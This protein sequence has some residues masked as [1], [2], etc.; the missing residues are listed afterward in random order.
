MEI[1][2]FLTVLLCLCLPTLATAQD[3]AEPLKVGVKIAPPFVIKGDDGQFTGISIDLWQLAAEKMNIRYS[4][5]ERDLG[6]VIDGLQDGSLDVAVAAL[7][8][9]A[10]RETLVDFT[11]PFYTTEL[12][13]AVPR[14]S[15]VIASVMGQL[16]SREFLITVSA[17]IGLLLLVGVLLWL[18]ER[19]HNAT[20]FGGTAA[21]GIGASFW[22]A[23][24]TM[25]TVG[26]G[27]KA[28]TTP[29]GRVI[30]LVWMFAAIIVISSFTAAIATSLTVGHLESSITG[31]DDLYKVSV[32][33][34]RDSA[35]EE[36]LQ[37][38]GIASSAMDDVDTALDALADREFDALAYDKPILKYLINKRTDNS[39]RL[40]P[41]YFERQ[42]YALA[43]PQNSALREPL[44]VAVLEVL[45]TL[46]WKQ[47]LVSYM[48]K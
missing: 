8:V 36:F 34:V 17:L 43:I 31:P 23:A 29:A 4:Y 24:V 30:A 21:E 35:S 19:K 11:N 39:V 38:S 42:H 9:T 44:N 2:K 37:V 41:Q 10:E 40:I 18:V 28:P 45:E 16:F 15:G 6:G 48:G 14:E 32:V 1:L 33:T 7:T 25:T 47:V 27:D 22:W 26:Y 12:A 3:S 20:M 13:I 5:V 46:Q